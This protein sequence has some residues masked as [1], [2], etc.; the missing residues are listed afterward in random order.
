MTDKLKL[1]SQ[2][3]CDAALD[4]VNANDAVYE[5]F[6][7][8]DTF[9]NKLEFGVIGR[10]DVACHLEFKEGKVVSF[11]PRTFDESELWLIIN[12]SLETWQAAAAGKEEGG[13]LLMKGQIKFAKGPMSAAIEN[14]GA[15]NNFLLTWGQV[16]TD[17]DV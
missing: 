13:K 8:P 15:L 12:G 10:D 17:W 3:W 4:A 1:F 6:K 7:D 16:P 5:G 9:T 11:T 2:E 14:A